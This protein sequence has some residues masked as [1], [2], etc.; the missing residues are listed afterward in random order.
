MYD[1]PEKIIPRWKG[2]P[3]ATTMSSQEFLDDYLYQRKALFAETLGKL[4]LDSQ[5]V[6][7][8]R[9]K[10]VVSENSKTVIEGSD[11]SIKA[12]K[13]SGKEFWH[14][15]KK[16]SRGFI[17]SY[18]AETDPETKAAMKD[19]GKDLDKWITEKEIQDAADVMDKVPDKGK[20][21]IAEKINKLKREMELFGP[22][23]VVSKYNEYGD[24][25]EE[26]DTYW[27]LDLPFLLVSSIQFS[28]TFFTL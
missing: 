9:N 25:E 28:P 4:D 6:L 8:S 27:W 19:I 18:N 22:Q 21:F 5:D 11:G 13:K 26:I 16:W 17:D 15:T 14:H 2:L 24:D 20:K 23:A 10:K 7:Q 1:S 3:P 12:G